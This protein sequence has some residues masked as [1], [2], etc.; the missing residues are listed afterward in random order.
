[1]PVP[2]PC[3]FVCQLEDGGDLCV[4]CY[5]TSAEI[6]EWSGATEEERADIVARATARAAS[7]A[8]AGP[9]DGS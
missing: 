4:G 1:M 9:P 6:M 2:S 3:I 7:R 8:E 5:R